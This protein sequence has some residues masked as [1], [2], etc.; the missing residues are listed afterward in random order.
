MSASE[1][2]L[3]WIDLEMTGLDPQRDRIIEI[4][5][6]VT[7]ADLNVLAEGPVIALHQDDAQLA[8]MDEWNVRTHTASGL[9]ARVKASQ[10]DDAAAE[11]ATLDFLRQWVPAGVSPICGNSVGQ[12][13]RFLFRYM[14][15]LE[16]YFHY[17]YL[18]VSTLKELARRWKPEILEGFKKKNTHQ[19]LDDI[20]ESVAELAY[21]R[22]HFI[23]L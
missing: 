3:I 19:A 4:A 7:D 11:Q 8:L 21:Y 5:T 22:T 23:Q 9:V 12:D 18:D 15:E 16:R 6:L 1:T 14:P 10:Y 17:R 20:R 2:R 13:R